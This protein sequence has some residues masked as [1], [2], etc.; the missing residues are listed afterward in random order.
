MTFSGRRDMTKDVSEAADAGAGTA[1]VSR[2]AA[3]HARLRHDLRR[4]L[5][6]MLVAD[7]TAYPVQPEEDSAIRVT[8]PTGL[9]PGRAGS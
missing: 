1:T 5:A 9:A 4:L 6:D 7:M 3:L 2:D 8:S